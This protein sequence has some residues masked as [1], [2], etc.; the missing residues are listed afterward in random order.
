MPAGGAPSATSCTALAAVR[1]PGLAVDHLAERAAPHVLP[2]L[3]QERRAANL[4]AHLHHAVVLARG[5]HRRLAFQDVVARR[6]LDVDVLAGQAAVNRQ[7]RV[8][9]IRRGHHEGVDRLVVEQLA[10]VLDQLGHLPGLR[11]HL[12]AALC[13][14]RLVDVAEV[15]DV[16]IRFGGEAV[17]HR[18]AAAADAD[19]GDADLVVRVRSDQRRRRGG[20]GRGDGCRWF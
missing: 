1:L 15:G 8:P 4:R 11:L 20:R 12:R 5:G 9:V 14:H 19:A 16:A 18:V 13:R 3:V 6:L 2:R 10:I 17:H 7:Q